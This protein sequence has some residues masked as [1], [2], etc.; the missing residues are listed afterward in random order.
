MNRRH[1]TCRSNLDTRLE[2][3][4]HLRRTARRMSTAPSKQ[5]H[6]PRSAAISKADN[7][8]SRRRTPP[9]DVPFHQ[10]I[11]RCWKTVQV[12]HAR[13]ALEVHRL[14]RRVLSCG[15]ILSHLFQNGDEVSFGNDLFRVTSLEAFHRM[16]VRRI[17]VAYRFTL[18]NETSRRKRTIHGYT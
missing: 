5:S 15:S 13:F 8:G 2:I 9:I 3:V 4:V 1:V 6:C 12:D 17:Q 11:P 16:N 10:L 7:D 14:S 18:S